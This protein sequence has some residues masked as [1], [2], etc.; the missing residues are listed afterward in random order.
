VRLVENCRVV[1]VLVGMR[2]CNPIQP[3]LC[4]VGGFN[5]VG[6]AADA[7]KLTS[8]KSNKG[9]SRLCCPIGPKGVC[10]RLAFKIAIRT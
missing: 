10:I 1:M 6:V 7:V 3:L 4:P 8:R 9:C 5:E 2:P